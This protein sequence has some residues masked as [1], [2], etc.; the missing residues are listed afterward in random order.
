M[1]SYL[2]SSVLALWAF[3]LF[4]C[5]QE[6]EPVPSNDPGMELAQLDALVAECSVCHGVSEAQR[7]PIL[8]GMDGWYLSDQMNKF[9]SGVRGARPSNRSEYLMGIGAR[10]I[11][12]DLQ[13]AY[14]AHWFSSQPAQPAIRTVRGDLE[15]GKGIYE[16]RCLS[17]HGQQGQGNPTLQSPSLTKLEG[18]YFLEQMRKFR[19]GERGYD[20]RDQAG[21]VMAAASKELSDTD[22]RDLVAY[23]IDEFGLEE[24][25]GVEPRWM[26]KKSS[27]PVLD[28]APN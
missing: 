23:C 21:K 15:S 22:L 10:K 2:L 16:R 11:Q 24:A 1:P 12:S 28:Q 13:V 3:G 19:S 18:W 5:K 14:L 6:V 7:G 8:N 20:P 26:P 27:K 17:C 4:G 9:R 25:K